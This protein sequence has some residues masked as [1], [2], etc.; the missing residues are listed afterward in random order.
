M[1]Q[2]YLALVAVTRKCTVSCL[3][4]DFSIQSSPLNVQAFCEAFSSQYI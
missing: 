1:R 2:L 4:V 3:I